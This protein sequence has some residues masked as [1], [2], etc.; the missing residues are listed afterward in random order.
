MRIMFA[1]Q[2]RAEVDG[3]RGILIT[4]LIEENL[5]KKL[6]YNRHYSRQKSA[7]KY[8]IGKLS[9]QPDIKFFRRKVVIA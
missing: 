4:K 3:R 2:K 8:L 1:I 7:F 6:K 5:A 9:E